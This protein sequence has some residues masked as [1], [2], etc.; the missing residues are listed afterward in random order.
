MEG[1]SLFW[2]LCMTMWYTVPISWPAICIHGDKV[3]T[4]REWV[5]NGKEECICFSSTIHFLIY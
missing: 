1:M 3:Q 2:L 4:E 5:L